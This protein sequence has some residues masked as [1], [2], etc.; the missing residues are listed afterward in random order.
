VR[1]NPSSKLCICGCFLLRCS[2]S[3]LNG[4]GAISLRLYAGIRL[5]SSPCFRTADQRF[6]LH[7]MKR[8]NEAPIMCAT[9]DAIPLRRRLI[10]KEW[11]SKERKGECIYL[12]V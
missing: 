9:I 3:F 11:M 6:L 10:H 4:A 8:N 1:S 5:T 2:L 12:D 7:E